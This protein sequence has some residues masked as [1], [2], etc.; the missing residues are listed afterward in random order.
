MSDEYWETMIAGVWRTASD[1][2]DEI[3]LDAIDTLVAERPADDAA[4]VFEAASVRDF[5]GLEPEAAPLYRRALELG[6]TGHRRPQAIIQLASTLRNLGEVEESITLLRGLLEEDPA[7]EWAA[8]AMAF[9]A[10]S[11][12]SSGDSVAATSVALTA[13]ADYLPAYSNSVRTYAAELS[14]EL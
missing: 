1:Y 5:I 2:S 3:I 7:G 11:L 6:L 10:L 4:A 12:A 9:L 13:L 14:A 8:P